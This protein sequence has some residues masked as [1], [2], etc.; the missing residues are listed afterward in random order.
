MSLR[1][2]VVD[3]TIVFRTILADVLKTIEDVEV[4]GTAPSGKAAIA[5]IAE[6]K[7]DLVT[8][9]I[10]MPGMNGIEVLDIIRQNNFQTGVIVVSSLTASGS[11]YTIQ[12]LEKGAFD[13]ITKP[14]EES[15]E[16]NRTFIKNELQPR[17][18]AFSRKREIQSI[19]K[20]SVSFLSAAG[21]SETEN[22]EQNLAPQ[23]AG[24]LKKIVHSQMILI[25]VST[26]G[27]GALAVIIPQ[28]PPTINV[29]VFIVQHMPP[30][31]T[32]ALAESLQSKSK[33]EVVEAA[34][35]IQVRPGCVYIAPGGKQMKL[36]K[37]SDNSKCIQITDDP[38]ENNC[39]P[40]VDY[41]FRSVANNFPSQ[42][43]AAILTGMGSDGTVGLKMLKR[44]GCHIIAQDEGSCVVFGMPRSAIEAGVVDE[45]VS[46]DRIASRLTEI[47]KRGGF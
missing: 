21:K 44:Q 22:R 8:L 35:G 3:D 34:N 42:S 36:V 11:S 2:L 29:P 6:L 33:V 5:K 27:P 37:A 40:S 32:Q 10:E 20:G 12:A 13:F 31:F 47:V 39:K 15:T 18:R 1:V 46:L 23:T 26:G 43:V 38:P 25:G 19:L 41:F 24:T 4:V 14:S 30:M 17:I 45:T 28:I 9:D 16:K 7:P